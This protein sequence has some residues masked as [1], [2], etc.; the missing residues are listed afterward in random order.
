M[1]RETD[2]AKLVI[3]NASEMDKT[4]RTEVADWLRMHADDLEKDG[5][6][7]DATFTG[8]FIDR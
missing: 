4:R 6:E 3:H 1:A 5:A 2:A 8:H 7:Y